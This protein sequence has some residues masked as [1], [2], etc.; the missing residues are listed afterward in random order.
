[1]TKALTHCRKA[2]QHFTVSRFPR[3]I[4]FRLAAAHGGRRARKLL[5]V[6]LAYGTE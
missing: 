6:Q 2:V 4:V 5:Q 1:M 3:D